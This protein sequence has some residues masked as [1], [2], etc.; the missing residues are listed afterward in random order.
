MSNVYND[1]DIPKD[2][3]K[4][5]KIS[6]DNENQIDDKTIP[7]YE[8]YK[9]FTLQEMNNYKNKYDNRLYY[10]F[11]K[12]VSLNTNEEEEYF[13]THKSA[14]MLANVTPINNDIIRRR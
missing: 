6:L 13:W 5:L 9:P 1:Y 14:V 8:Q 7:Y 2:K 3:T 11:N 12:R 10:S 4:R